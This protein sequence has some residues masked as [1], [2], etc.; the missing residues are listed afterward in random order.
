MNR[1]AER[2][3]PDPDDVDAQF[4]RIVAGYH[5][6]AP[7][8]PDIE[9]GLATAGEDP[10]EEPG[11]AP[12]AVPKAGGGDFT[13]LTD[14][15]AHSGLGAADPRGP[16]PDEPGLLEGL[17]T[18]G[19]GLP[20]DPADDEG[21]TPPPPPPLPSLAKYTV[22]AIVSIL[23]G[24]VLLLWPELLP[25]DQQVTMLAGFAG[26]VGGVVTLVYRLRSGEDDDP[27]DDGARV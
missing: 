12:R 9:L 1:D 27:S 21:Y 10:V 18:F 3:E 17:D 14:L 6:D 20:D 15:T 25:I 5:R 23:A 24:F 13:T 4:A 26:L 2:A 19:S 16:G 7:P 22:A 11:E 8:R